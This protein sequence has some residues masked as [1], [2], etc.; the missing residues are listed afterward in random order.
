MSIT[1]MIDLITQRTDRVGMCGEKVTTTFKVSHW[2]E[3][4]TAKIPMKTKERYIKIL[5]SDVEDVVNDSGKVGRLIT[6][7]HDAIA[8]P[9][10]VVPDSAEEFYDPD[11]YGVK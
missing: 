5:I 7:L 9:M 11:Y 10:G 2:G 4:T 8:L 3:C 6:A 1:P